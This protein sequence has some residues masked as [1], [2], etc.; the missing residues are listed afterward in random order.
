MSLTISNGIVL[1]TS[2]EFYDT[3]SGDDSSS[4]PSMR[5]NGSSSGGSSASVASR[6]YHGRTGGASGHSRRGSFGSSEPDNELISFSDGEPQH[7]DINYLS[8][9]VSSLSKKLTDMEDSR[10][11]SIDERSRLKT[12]NA[13]LNERV[14]MLEEQSMTI[15]SRLT[16]RLEDE[17]ARHRDIIARVDREKQLEIESASLKYQVLE[18][19]IAQFRAEKEKQEGITEKMRK[20]MEKLTDQLAESEMAREESEEMRGELEREFRRYKETAQQDM[21]SSNELMEEL[22]RQTHEM[23]QHFPRQTSVAE[24]LSA[25]EEE[26]ARMR[27]E[28]RRMRKE[29]EELQAQLLHDSLERGR[30]LLEDGAGTSL[31]DELSGKD[32]TEL[33][34]ALREQEVCN[35]KLKQYINGILMRVITLHPEI[36][37][38]PAPAE[39]ARETPSPT[40][41]TDS[42]GS[43]SQRLYSY[44]PTTKW[45]FFRRS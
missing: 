33:L 37:E 2:G 43:L 3:A 40:P 16:E 11:L 17:R 38:I 14:H 10:A 7:N 18:K 1:D 31:A 35:F 23:S 6:L 13:R 29:N 20:E 44:I 22:S 19:D 42:S 32:T 39:D 24:Q 36:L 5:L 4:S 30:S 15:E 26:A 25:A 21:D 34:E 12:E 28:C 27:E 8:T 41:S 45:S 9:Q